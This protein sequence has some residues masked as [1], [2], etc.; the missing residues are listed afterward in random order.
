MR[1]SRWL[2]HPRRNGVLSLEPVC[3][4]PICC[5]RNNCAHRRRSRQ[6]RPHCLLARQQAGAVL[7]DA[8]FAGSALP[9]DAHLTQKNCFWTNLAGIYRCWFPARSHLTVATIVNYALA[10][11]HLHNDL[12]LAQ[13]HGNRIRSGM[14]TSIFIPPYKTILPCLLVG[15]KSSGYG[16]FGVNAIVDEFS[17]KW[18]G[19]T[20][21]PPDV[22]HQTLSPVL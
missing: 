1:W 21:A 17:V 7:I 14:F 18:D 3:Q 13:R 6:R 9:D 8:N 15:S 16:R 5:S 12:T 11:V 19:L 4:L 10:A 20:V 2:A 22:L